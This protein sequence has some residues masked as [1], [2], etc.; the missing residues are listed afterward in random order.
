MDRRLS[1]ALAVA[2]L[3]SVTLKVTPDGAHPAEPLPAEASEAVGVVP[4]PGMAS[5]EGHGSLFGDDAPWPTDEGGESAFLAEARARG[6]SVVPAR[7]TAP[8]DDAETET[9]PLPPL[10][11]L[12]QRIPAEVRELLEELYRVKFTTV[13]RV[14]AR[15]L[16]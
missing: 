13:R 2:A 4:L 7:P 12:V 3:P 8:K 6:E 11:D 15:A 1:A 9:A 5:D 14:P 16:K 10:D